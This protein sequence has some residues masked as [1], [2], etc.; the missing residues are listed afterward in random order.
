MKIYLAARFGRRVEL[1]TYAKQ[2][3]LQGH[4]ITSRW[5]DTEDANTSLA[6]SI[7]NLKRGSMPDEAQSFANIDLADISAA[8]LVISFT[9]RSDSQHGRGGR[10]VEFGFARALK[11]KLIIIGPRENVFHTL[12]GVIHFEEW[13]AKVIASINLTTPGTSVHIHTLKAMYEFLRARN[14]GTRRIEI[15]RHLYS[16]DLSGEEVS[17]AIVVK[18]LTHAMF[19]RISRGY[20]IHNEDYVASFDLETNV[21]TETD[22]PVITGSPRKPF[23]TK[24]TSCICSVRK[25]CTYTRRIS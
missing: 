2:L 16:L 18:L 11:K 23:S 17:E 12:E 8:E 7:E 6:L 24:L 15:L 25:R 4:F 1:Q 5:L 22:Q 19:H 21:L 10:H 20:Y 13:N 9:E 3:N 14:K